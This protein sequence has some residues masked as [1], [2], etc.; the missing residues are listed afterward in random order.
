MKS[1]QYTSFEH[2][3]TQLKILR[4]QSAIEKEQLAFNYHKIKHLFY[5][6]NLALELGN[7][8]QQKLISLILNRFY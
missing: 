2:I 1:N 3:D 8:V 4:L 5:P 7:I 6:K